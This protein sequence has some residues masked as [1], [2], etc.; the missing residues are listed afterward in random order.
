MLSLYSFPDSLSEEADADGVRRATS[1]DEP[2][3]EL[4]SLNTI[5]VN[6]PKRLISRESSFCGKKRKQ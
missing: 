2:N 6:P 5:T 3:D 4:D 1:I